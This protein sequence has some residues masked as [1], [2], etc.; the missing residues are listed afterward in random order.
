MRSRRRAEPTYLDCG[1]RSRRRIETP[2]S[3]R[4][5]FA[6]ERIQNQERC[7]RPLPLGLTPMLYVVPPQP[8]RNGGH[9]IELIRHVNWNWMTGVRALGHASL[10]LPIHLAGPC[11][12]GAANTNFARPDN[13]DLTQWLA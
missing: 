3:P 8:R 2:R 11:V 6:A 13:W 4:R 10:H 9:E 12:P 7:G 1:L 5:S